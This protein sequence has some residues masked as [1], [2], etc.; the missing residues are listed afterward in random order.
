MR[1]VIILL[2]ICISSSLTFAQSEDFVEVSIDIDVPY[3]GQPLIYSI[4][5]YTTR[6]VQNTTV[7]EPR[8]DGFGR[9]SFVSD[10][11]VSSEARNG[12]VYTVVE[13]SLLLYPLRAGEQTIDPL[14]IEIPETPFESATSV[15]TEALTTECSIITR[16]RTRIIQKCSRTI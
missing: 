3:V 11:T 13:H 15:Q 6:D 16:W 9:S 14:R 10:A 5:V 1:R 8:F 2:L 4:R 7:I 12:S